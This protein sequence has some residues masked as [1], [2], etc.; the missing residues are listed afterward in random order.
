MAYDENIRI[1]AEELERLKNRPTGDKLPEVEATDEG[2]VLT[3]NASGEWDAEELPDQ[4]P[5]VET[6]DEGKVLTVNSSGKW[7]A[8]D[9]SSSYDLDY[10]STEKDTGKKWIDGRTIYSKVYQVTANLGTWTQVVDDST[11][12]IISWNGFYERA[13][14][15]RGS[16]NRYS[17][18]T[19]HCDSIVYS[20]YTKLQVEVDDPDSVSATITVIVE[21]VKKT[22]QSKKKGA[23]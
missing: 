17:S 13:D 4:L 8:A 19:V 15:I 23:K 9:P 12:E 18:S 6:T 7:A 11:I 3:V 10:S 1:I 5:S 14:K 2:K 20:D 21:Y 16:I 22:T